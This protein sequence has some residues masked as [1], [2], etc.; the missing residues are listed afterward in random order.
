MARIYS[1]GMTTPKGLI[2]TAPEPVDQRTVVEN[3]ADLLNPA[4]NAYPGLMVTVLNDEGATKP[5]YRTYKLEGTDSSILDN[6][7]I[8]GTGVVSPGDGGG[9]NTGTAGGKFV[10]IVF[11]RATY[12]PPPTPTGGN[13]ETPT[14]TTQDGIVWSNQTPIG[15]DTLYL[16][17]ATFEDVDNFTASWSTPIP[18]GDTDAIDFE[19]A[20]DD[21]RIDPGTGLAYN[22][23]VPNTDYWHNENV[24]AEDVW[25]AIGVKGSGATV[26]TVFPIGGS[27]T[28][29]LTGPAGLAYRHTAIFTRDERVTEAVR[30]FGGTWDDPSGSLQTKTF[31]GLTSI[32]G[33]IWSE[34]I[35][36]GSKKLWQC[37]YTFND[38]DTSTDFTREWSIP[39]PLT[40]TAYIDFKFSEETVKPPD[41]TSLPSAWTEL[42][43]TNTI[44]VAQRTVANGIIPTDSASGWSIWRAQGT[45]GPPGKGMTITGYATIPNILALGVQELFTVYIA[46]ADEAGGDIP[47]NAGDAYLYVGAGNGTAGTDWDNIGGITGTDAT[48]YKNS[49]VFKR[50]TTPPPAPSGGTF[51]DP[52]PPT[53][54]WEDGYPA[55]VTGTKVYMTS[56]FFADNAIIDAALEDWKTPT[57]AMDTETVD[58]QWAQKQFLDAEPLPPDTAGG[59]IWFDASDPRPEAGY[60]W[61]AT[62][63]KNI[64]GTVAPGTW[65]VNEIRGE[66]GD[67]GIPG[68][69]SFQ[70]SAY[71]RTNETLT[72]VPTGGSYAN[73]VPNTG[74]GDSVWSDGIPTGGKKLWY[75][76][77]LVTLDQT[78]VWAPPALVGDSETLEFEFS[79]SIIQP[80]TPPREGGG[81]GIWYDSVAEA[82]AAT[83]QPVQWMA[84]AVIKSEEWPSDTDWNYIQVTGEVGPRGGDGRTYIPST[85]F[86]RSDEEYFGEEQD[87][88]AQYLVEDPESDGFIV[89]GALPSRVIGGKTYQFTDGIPV[90]TDDGSVNDSRYIWQLTGVFNSVNHLGAAKP[91]NWGKPKLLV[92]SAGIDYQY[93]TGV[94]VSHS[95][96]E[97]PD[98]EGNGPGWYDEPEDPSLIALGGAYWI[99]QRNFAEGRGAPW[100][101]YKVKG[102]DGKDGEDAIAVEVTYYP[103]R[104]SLGYAGERDAA[105]PDLPNTS[106][107]LKYNGGNK[108]IGGSYPIVGNNIFETQDD[109]VPYDGNYR[110]HRVFNDTLVATDIVLQI[111]T[112]GTIMDVL[113]AEKVWYFKETIMNR[114]ESFYISSYWNETRKQ[115]FH[116]FGSADKIYSAQMYLIAKRNLTIGSHNYAIGERIN[117]SPTHNSDND[118]RGIQ[119]SWTD[120]LVN[121]IMGRMKVYDKVIGMRPEDNGS[122]ADDN[123]WDIKIV[124]LGRYPVGP[125]DE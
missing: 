8:I 84:I 109:T 22:P 42:A 59:G 111:S 40:D 68:A 75:T 58:I 39:G 106:V 18:V 78:P 103:I 48:S 41:P 110:F 47:G 121:V 36:V 91:L 71:V 116:N 37:H 28:I 52:V 76:R 32:A 45:Q 122:V 112:D 88:I 50:A 14:P 120:T 2:M 49:F 74:G 7:V 115:F 89:E 24:P 33:V 66:K 57:L 25:M 27:D 77:S 20:A 65:V 101:I 1:Q 12:T 73:P 46:S 56:R 38:E 85:I 53:G 5:A 3:E 21:A 114:A 9:T 98:A 80:A 94:G 62:G 19:F 100:K 51:A 61:M 43:T 107:D 60:Q 30:V 34:N 96:P 26:W 64:D 108:G 15:T 16:S 54:G 72:E 99:A 104:I 97:A 83:S 67:D 11:T 63:V 117:A 81:D 55:P 4:L 124:L 93:S 23:G 69:P 44:W 79:T 17:M 123:D 87:F 102:E 105:N 13:Y 70:A 6:W 113:S 86:C 125:D 29:G 95:A 82:E 10:S 90:K 118:I 31:P 35:P 119:L 92:D